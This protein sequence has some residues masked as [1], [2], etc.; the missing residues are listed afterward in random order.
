MGRDVFE[1]KV[2]ASDGVVGSGKACHGIIEIECSV[3]ELDREKGR[4]GGE[5]ELPNSDV[6]EK[7][8]PDKMKRTVTADER[9]G[10]AV[11]DAQ[12]LSV[13]EFDLGAGFF[14]TR[15]RS[16]EMGIGFHFEDG[17]CVFKKVVL[18]EF[19]F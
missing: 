11:A 9:V 5:F 16:S 13:G 19:E 3:C 12:R 7:L 2:E 15:G 6:T 8:V 1:L 18:V 14:D 17:L 10:R 4:E